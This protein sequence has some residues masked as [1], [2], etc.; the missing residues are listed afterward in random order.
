MASFLDYLNQVVPTEG[1][2]LPEWIRAEMTPQ[3]RIDETF[4]PKGD[5]NAPSFYDQFRPSVSPQ[6]GPPAPASF[7][8]RFNFPSPQVPPEQR[9]PAALDTGPAPLSLSPQ[10]YQQPQQPQPQQPQPQQQGGGGFLDRLSMALQ[11]IVNPQTPF[12]YD[13]LRQSGVPH[14]QAL[15]QAAD[16]KTAEFNAPTWGVIAQD[17]FGTPKYGWIDRA[18][19]QIRVPGGGLGIAEAVDKDGNPLMGQAYLQ[20]LEKNSPTMAAAIKGALNGDQNLTGRRLQ[21]ALA[22]ASRVD[23]NFTPAVYNARKQL[24]AEANK[25]TPN[26]FGGQRNAGNTAVQ[27]L[28]DVARYAEGLGNWDAGIPGISHLINYARQNLSTDQATAAN[29]LNTAIDRYVAEVAKFYAGSNTGG[30]AEREAAR[31]RFSSVKTSKE[32]AGAIEAE[33]DLFQGKM[34]QLQ[35]QR[36]NAFQGDEERANRLVGPI[37]MSHGT[38]GLGAIN[39]SVSALQG[40]S[41]ASAAPAGVTLDAVTQEIERRKKMRQQ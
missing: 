16:L 37:M 19:Q 14:P 28:G 15:L 8:E 6:Y 12:T 20:H 31:Q 35:D 34:K 36:D 27:H 3:Q 11:G 41:P 26:S 17:D 25:A 30:V 24:I 10:N 13:A 38:E 40:N 18:G 32:L 1:G 9:Q 33:R 4:N 7:D 29:K 22:A 23:E 21:M 2:V 39:K 5:Y